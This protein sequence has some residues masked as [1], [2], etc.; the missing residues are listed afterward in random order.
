MRKP[1]ESPTDPIRTKVKENLLS[2]LNEVTH[3]VAFSS[4]HC[5]ISGT[6][7]VSLTIPKSIQCNFWVK[8]GRHAVILTVELL[9]CCSV[10]FYPIAPHLHGSNRS[11][12][13]TDQWL[14][15]KGSA[16]QCKRRGFDPWVRKM[17]L[18]EEMAAHSSIFAWR[19]P[20]TEEPGGLQ[21]MGS[22]RVGHNWATE[23]VHTHTHTHTSISLR[24]TGT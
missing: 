2:K 12:L 11:L 4:Y 9:P 13:S 18:Q 19:I 3:A 23:C 14:S 20:W 8:M 1:R 15:G 10:L 24:D 21:S 17:P 16:C 22:Q 7:R 6:V 5:K